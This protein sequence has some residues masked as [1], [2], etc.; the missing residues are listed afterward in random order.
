MGG[1][2]KGLPERRRLIL[3]II[4]HHELLGMLLIGAPLFRLQIE[5]DFN[6]V[7]EDHL[8]VWDAVAVQIFHIHDL[9]PHPVGGVRFGHC[10]RVALN[11]REGALQMSG[12]ARH[13]ND[14]AIGAQS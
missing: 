14:H 1:H 6:G 13:I 2:R 8:R 12:V 7:K 10:G 4:L 3:R 5:T 9:R 11:N